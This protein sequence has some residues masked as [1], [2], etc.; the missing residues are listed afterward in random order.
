[1]Y[2]DYKVSMK[3]LFRAYKFPENEKA[4]D[5]DAGKS[6]YEKLSNQIEMPIKIP[7]HAPVFERYKFVMKAKL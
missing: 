1:M 5:L 4:Q 6:Y 3:Q 7:D 2:K